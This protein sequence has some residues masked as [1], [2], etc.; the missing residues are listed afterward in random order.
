MLATNS[1]MWKLVDILWHHHC[2]L[3]PPL[4]DEAWGT[5]AE[6]PYS[7]LT[8]QHYPGQASASDWLK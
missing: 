5:S 8:M 3:S 1:T 4:W 6:I 7:I 2:P